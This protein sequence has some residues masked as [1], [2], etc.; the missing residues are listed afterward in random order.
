MSFFDIPTWLIHLSI[1]YSKRFQGLLL[2][3]DQVWNRESTVAAKCK[4]YRYYS[5]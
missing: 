4:H 5:L 2:Q 1:R 3:K